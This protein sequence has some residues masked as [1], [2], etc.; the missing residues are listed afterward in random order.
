MHIE[1]ILFKKAVL[2]FSDL[3]IVKNLKKKIMCIDVNNKLV[4]E[5]DSIFELNSNN[6]QHK[7][8]TDKN[9][10]MEKIYFIKSHFKNH[11]WRLNINETDTSVAIA[12]SE[13]QVFT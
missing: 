10:H 3:F 6:I 4:N 9:I 2:I 13:H 7:S 8:T 1:K 12:G 5:T 11:Y